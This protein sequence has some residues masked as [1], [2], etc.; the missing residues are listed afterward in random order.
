M[1]VFVF[2]KNSC[3][4]YASQNKNTL[5]ESKNGNIEIKTKDMKDD[6]GDGCINRPVPLNNGATPYTVIFT[7]AVP[8]P[9]RAQPMVLPIVPP[10]GGVVI[11]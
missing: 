10:Q 9:Q 5:T 2:E 6:A 1:F 7:G 4:V 8:T 3:E 11:Y